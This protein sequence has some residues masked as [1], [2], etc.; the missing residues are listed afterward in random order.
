MKNIFT[1]IRDT[2]NFCTKSFLIPSDSL[3]TA[4]DL[5]HPLNSLACSYNFLSLKQTIP[6]KP[7]PVIICE[8]YILFV[9]ISEYFPKFIS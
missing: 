1:I 8:A 2:I 4:D 7:A 3:N 5:P 9:V 6:P